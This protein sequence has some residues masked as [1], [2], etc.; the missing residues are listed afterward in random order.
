MGGSNPFNVPRE[1]QTYLGMMDKFFENLARN[2]DEQ[3]DDIQAE[4][5]AYKQVDSPSESSPQQQEVHVHIHTGN[6]SKKSD[7]SKEDEE[8]EK[9]GEEKEDDSD[10]ELKKKKKKKDDKKE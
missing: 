1:N 8:D 9:D 6:A 3:R 5:E 2:I 10:M 4:E 7:N